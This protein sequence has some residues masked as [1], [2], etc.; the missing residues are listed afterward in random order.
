MTRHL[1][2]RELYICGLVIHFLG[3]WHNFIATTRGLL[4][5]KNFLS[6]ETYTD[7]VLSCH[8]AITII[9][10]MRDNFPEVPCHLQLTGTDL[11]ESYFSKNGQWV[12]NRHHYSYARMARNLSHMIRLVSIRV[13]PNAPSFARPHPKT[14]FIWSRQYKHAWEPCN[15]QVYPERGQEIAAFREGVYLARYWAQLAG[16]AP[17]GL[18]VGPT[19]DDQHL[20]EPPYRQGPPPPDGQD[21]PP[22]D[23]QQPPPLLSE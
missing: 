10:F 5:H 22:P 9:Y 3:I 2:G 17:Q 20:P 4:L 23:S 6:R 15:L 18:D 7:V 1:F 13:D 11:V 19:P 16:L 21:P 8:M 14:E 12:G